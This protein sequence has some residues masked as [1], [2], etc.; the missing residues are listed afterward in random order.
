MKIKIK[1]SFKGQVVEAETDYIKGTTQ[2]LPDIYP[3]NQKIYLSGDDA[4]FL[5]I[6][7]VLEDGSVE[8]CRNSFLI[9]IEGSI[10]SPFRDERII[11][12][13]KLDE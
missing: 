5:G 6:V 10:I 11:F 7:S 3:F 9:P 2:R 4:I 1:A 12:S 13:F 8:Y